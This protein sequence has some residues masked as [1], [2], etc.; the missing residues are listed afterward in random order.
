MENNQ[1]EDGMKKAWSVIGQVLSWLSIILAILILVFDQFGLFESLAKSGTFV[2]DT[3]SLILKTIL[4]LIAS[5]SAASLISLNTRFDDMDTSLDKKLTVLSQ[6]L[7]GVTVQKYIL[8]DD[9]FSYWTER[10]KDVE[11]SIEHVA[12]SQPSKFLSKKRTEYEKSVSRILK[13]SKVKYRYVAKLGEKA[14]D[15]SKLRRLDVLSRN[16]LDDQIKKYSVAY[17]LQK[18]SSSPTPLPSFMIL[19]NKEVITLYPKAFDR[20][21]TILSI[22]HPEVVK[23]YADYFDSL[24]ANAQKLDR[25]KVNDL[26]EELNAEL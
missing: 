24:W 11:T 5:F 26:I 8:V 22:K 2:I 4:L 23:M 15:G 25:T 19:D 20:D 6:G 13:L 18:P 21:E 16:L 10:L 14:E 12:F 1:G 9:G 3:N 17:Y 7:N